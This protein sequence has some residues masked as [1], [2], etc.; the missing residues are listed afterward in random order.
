[1][2]PTRN[3]SCSPPGKF[4]KGPRI[5]KM[6]LLVVADG[7]Y[8]IDV[9]EAEGEAVV[10]ESKW[11]ATAVNE[12]TVIRAVKREV[13]LDDVV[14]GHVRIDAVL[15]C[16]ATTRKEALKVVVD[17]REGVDELKLVV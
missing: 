11:L 8:V 13:V 10:V 15:V 7:G 2:A 17:Q 4:S 1:M 9:A 16:S 3:L 6:P 5:I 12:P 14:V